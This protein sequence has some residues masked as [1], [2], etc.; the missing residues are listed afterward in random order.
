MP[1]SCALLAVDVEIELRR[2]VLEQREHLRQAR[3]LRGL[4][5]HGVGR[6]QQ[7]LRAAAG[8]ILDHHA[9]AAGVADA[10]DRRRQHHEHHA[11]PGSAR[12]CRTARAGCR[13]RT[14][15]DPW[16]ASRTDRSTRKTAP[17]FGALVKVAPEKPTMF[18]A[19]I[20]ARHLQRDVDDAP[21]HLVGARQR[22][23]GRQLRH[24]DEIA[25][26]ELRDEADRRLAEFVEAEG[27]DAGIDQQHD[28]GEAHHPRGDPAIAL[29][30]ACRSRN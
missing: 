14:G 4:A 21:L 2:R 20:D 25:A 8:A 5:H 28:H 7:R 9:E 26:V 24:H 22:R 6:V 1:R 15:W 17:A 13:R 27:D 29:R 12:A 23:A 10:R 30:R 3:R 19:P 18:I 16:R 11:P